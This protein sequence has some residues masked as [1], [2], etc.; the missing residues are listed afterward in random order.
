MQLRAKLL[1]QLTVKD[2]TDLKADILEQHIQL[3]PAQGD[4]LI[5]I[6]SE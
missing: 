1:H 4:L 6:L 2:K 3:A 5:K